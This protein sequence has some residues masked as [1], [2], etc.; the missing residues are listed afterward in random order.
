MSAALATDEAVFLVATA[1]M[2]E[3]IRMSE[4]APARGQA[5]DGSARSIPRI[6]LSKILIRAITNPQ[7]ERIDML[8]NLREIHTDHGP[9][10]GAGVPGFR[11]VYLFGPDANRAVL[12]DKDRI[13]SARRPWMAIMGRI[14]PNGLLLLDGDEH[15]Q[16]R[17]IMHTAF[18][19]PVL[20]EYT[21]RMNPIVHDAI[22]R[23]RGAGPGF[24]IFPAIK[25]LT[26]DMAARIFVGEELDAGTSRMNQSFEAM[27]AA[28]MSRVRLPIPGL[29]FQRGL[30]ARQF[31]VDFFRRRTTDRRA[32][33]GGDIFSRLCRA[34]TDEGDQFTD[35]Q[36]IDHMSFLMMAA[37]DTTTS[38]LSS[39][40][41]E[42]ARHPE[43]QERVRE[44]SVELDRDELAF[45]DLDSLTTL[46]QVF[47]ETLRRYPPLPVIPR[48]ATDD[49][50]FDGYV[51]RKD[52]M[53]V[54]SPILT[55]HM[56]KWWDDPFRFD[57]DR[58]SEKRAEHERH[59][60]SWIPFGG[61]PH[62]CLG[63]RF[64]EAQVKT[65]V[66]HV[67]RRYRL[68]VPDGYRMPVQQA[69]ISKPMD[70]LPMTLAAID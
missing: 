47:R 20:R 70:G 48:M 54:V 61:G 11:M 44:E 36:I 59:T 1:A 57:P 27:V 29:E 56:E 35:R 50:A 28:S 3:T 68:N 6:G 66:H 51:I 53:V 10:A 32:G 33:D 42:L 62:M 4:A 67:V 26:L 15:K 13:F 49:F 5:E 31:M 7:N 37:H 58:F 60:H 22:G 14:F 25:E 24:Q 45:D 38:T 17:K 34:E 30:A 43:W 19:R 39:M 23:W 18:T 8:G 2:P 46:T 52:T 69:P 12:L 21:A 16:H 40:F 65:I 63:L 9:V 41:Y 64:A 55:H